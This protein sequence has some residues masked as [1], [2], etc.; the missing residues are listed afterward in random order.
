MKNIFKIL[1]GNA[2][3]R[4]ILKHTDQKWNPRKDTKKTK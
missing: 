3:K 2:K 4:I 1:N